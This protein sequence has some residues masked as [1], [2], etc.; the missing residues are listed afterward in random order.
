MASSGDSTASDGIGCARSVARTKDT[1][2]R[3]LAD[4]W[5]ARTRQ[6][7]ARPRKGGTAEACRARAA[8]HEPYALLLVPYEVLL[9][10]GPCGAAPRNVGSYS[11]GLP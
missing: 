7:S 1:S 8:E 5:L 9:Q 4:R 2:C 6:A 11:D 10:D 3:S